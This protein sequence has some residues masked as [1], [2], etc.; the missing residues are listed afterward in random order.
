V[1]FTPAGTVPE[2]VSAEKETKSKVPAWR[3]ERGKVLWL[4]R[5]SFMVGGVSSVSEAS[6]VPK[7]H[8]TGKNQ[9]K[10]KKMQSLQRSF[11][12]IEGFLVRE[13]K[14]GARTR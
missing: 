13:G 3:F 6:V 7:G 9:G 1:I 14:I 5:S 12:E 11:L 2:K 10:K 4:G 8:G